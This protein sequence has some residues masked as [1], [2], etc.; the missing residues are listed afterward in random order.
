MLSPRVT[1]GTQEA[2]LRACKQALILYFVVAFTLVIGQV[3]LA[4]LAFIDR[5][6][7]LAYDS[8]LLGAAYL[9]AWRGR[10]V[11]WCMRFT[12]KVRL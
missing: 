12:D 5:D 8:M 3:T 10:G 6:V 7:R 1:P 9:F 11:D 4:V 2:D